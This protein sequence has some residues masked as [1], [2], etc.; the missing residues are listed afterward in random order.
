MWGWGYG[1][2]AE[3][4]WSDGSLSPKKVPQFSGYNIRQIEC[5]DWSQCAALTREGDMLVWG[6]FYEHSADETAVGAE[7]F[8][9]DTN[10]VVKTNLPR[11]RKVIFIGSTGLAVY[12]LL[13]D[14]R[15]VI[16]PTRSDSPQFI[17]PKA[18][19]DVSPG[20]ACHGR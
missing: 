10:D 7:R 8:V 15:L 14:G 12:G 20:G 3:A 11:G 16:F 18:W 1:T 6:R 13:D 19:I 5:A 4:F 9:D 2:L 17:D